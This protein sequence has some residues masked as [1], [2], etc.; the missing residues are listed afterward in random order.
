MEDVRHGDILNR[1][2]LASS[3]K[4]TL[5]TEDNTIEVIF[6]ASRGRVPKLPFHSL[7]ELRRLANIR[8]DRFGL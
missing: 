4:P 8:R 3:W 6:R 1:G 7:E 2:P 5:W